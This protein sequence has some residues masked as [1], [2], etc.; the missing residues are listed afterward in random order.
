M[1]FEMREKGRFQAH[2]ILFTF[3]WAAYCALQNGWQRGS[4]ARTSVCGWPT[5]HY[6]CL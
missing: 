6:L 3:G 1:M 5:F 2:E 4:V